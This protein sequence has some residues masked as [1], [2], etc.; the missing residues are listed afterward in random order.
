LQLEIKD[1]KDIKDIEKEEIRSFP[2]IKIHLNNYFI[3]PGDLK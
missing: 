1:I 2:N 3:A